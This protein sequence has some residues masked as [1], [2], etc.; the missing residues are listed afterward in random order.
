MDRGSIM[1]KSFQDGDLVAKKNHEIVYGDRSLRI[2]FGKLVPAEK[3][4]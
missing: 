3:L 4:F 2:L 1:Q